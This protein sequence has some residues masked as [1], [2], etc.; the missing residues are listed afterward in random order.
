MNTVGAGAREGLCKRVCLD[1]HE[2]PPQIDSRVAFRTRPSGQDPGAS[3]RRLVAE[4]PRGSRPVPYST[5]RRGG[6]S[7]FAATRLR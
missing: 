6:V 3:L 5:V 1:V 2:R 4:E 7:A